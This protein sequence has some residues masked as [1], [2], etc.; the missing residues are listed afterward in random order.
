M[1]RSITP[2]PLLGNKI[3]AGE[4]GI[5]MI[6]MA[7][8][9]TA[10]VAFLALMFNVAN[11]SLIRAQLR[12][13]A[14]AAA[15]AG[16]GNICSSLSC[17]DKSRIVA[18]E[19]LNSFRVKNNLGQPEDIQIDPMETGPDYSY[20]NLTIKIERGFWRSG[21][22]GPG[23]FVPFEDPTTYP[24][25]PK[26]A[27]ANAIR[28]S[29]SRTSIVPLMDSI[30]QGAL[31]WSGAAQAVAVASQLKA[32]EV[33]PFAIPLC[34]LINSAGDFDAAK[35]CYG[36][37][38]FAAS[39]R[40]CPSGNPDC[41]VIPGFPFEPL[42]S[43][44]QM[45]RDCQVAPDPSPPALCEYKYDNACGFRSPHYESIADHYG[46]VGI[47]GVN[48]TPQ[49]AE[50]AELINSPTGST[51]VAIG[52]PFSILPQGLTSMDSYDAM[53]WQMFS[54]HPGSSS[55]PRLQDTP[56]QDFEY[57]IAMHIPRYLNMPDMFAVP[58]GPAVD[59]P[60][61]LRDVDTNGACN[62]ARRDFSGNAVTQQSL[63]VDQLASGLMSSIAANSSTIADPVWSSLVPVI[64]DFGLEGKSCQ[65]VDGAAVENA[66]D[67]GEGHDWEIVGFLHSDI[68]DFDIAHAPPT[69][70]QVLSSNHGNTANLPVTFDHGSC[71]MIRAKLRCAGDLIPIS[72]P[73]GARRVA[74]V[75]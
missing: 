21:V 35:V 16:A 40:Y 20:G 12:G 50:V 2:T 47:P 18:I 15:F 17:W 42:T 72:D 34:S 3:A 23:S 10:I 70:D 48:A 31:N 62:S 61:L 39:N 66:V 38:L 43:S 69:V 59:C 64:A 68:F 36:E 19:T 24:G 63:P 58:R 14:D 56:L 6:L 75:Q 8:S 30:F 57:N 71:N 67:T 74:V 41:K 4:D 1:A 25:V 60:F 65:G 53:H 26:F 27:A 32:V 54:N 33:A 11:Y 46:V 52:M 5:A 45:I 44:A 13:A 7:I 9:L 28:V 73:D 55:H 37:R 29:L 22:G 51:A 49:E